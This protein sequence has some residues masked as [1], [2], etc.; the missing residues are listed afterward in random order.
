[1][2]KIITFAITAL[3]ALTIQAQLAVDSLGRVNIHNP[4]S[5]PA[6]TFCFRLFLL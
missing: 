1:M 2:K 3:I 6:Y 4:N 5:K